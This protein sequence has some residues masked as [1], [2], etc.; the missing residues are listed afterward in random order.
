LLSYKLNP[1]RVIFGQGE[2]IFNSRMITR[3]G[4]K[5]FGQ[6]YQGFLGEIILGFL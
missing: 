5:Y 6:G 2:H 1:D 3:K 4:V